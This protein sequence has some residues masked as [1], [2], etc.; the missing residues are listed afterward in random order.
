VAGQHGPPLDWNLTNGC[1]MST[2][3]FSF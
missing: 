2:P 1:R 3:F